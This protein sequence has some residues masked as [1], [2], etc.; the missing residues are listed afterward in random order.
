MSERPTPDQMAV[1]VDQGQQS[2]LGCSYGASALLDALAEHG[3]AI[4]HP[5]DVPTAE[6]RARVANRWYRLGW[7]ACRTHIF[8][9][10]ATYEDGAT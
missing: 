1:L 9:D 10:R 2:L 3:Y 5:D 7:N 8:G 4:V 6:Q